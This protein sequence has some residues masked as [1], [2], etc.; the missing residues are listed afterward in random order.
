ME[1][2]RRDLG[3]ANMSIDVDKNRGGSKRPGANQEQ[4]SGGPLAL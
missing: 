3:T 1:G 2:H 4:G